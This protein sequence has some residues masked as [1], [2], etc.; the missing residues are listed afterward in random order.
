M[1]ANPQASRSMAFADYDAVV[2]GAGPAGSSAAASLAAHGRRVLLVERDRFP[3]HKVCGEFLSPEAQDTLNALDLTDAVAVQGPTSLTHVEV[4][5]RGGQHLR[6]PLPAA[7][8]GISR[9]AL[10]GA[11]AQAAA[12]R[13]VTLWTATT[14]VRTVYQGGRYWVTLRRGRQYIH[15]TARTVLLA[16]GRQVRAALCPQPPPRTTEEAQ[17]APLSRSVGLKRH[18]DGVAI[19]DQVEL[20]LFPGGY[21]GINPV[22][23]GRANLCLLVEEETFRAAGGQVESMIAAAGEANPALGERLAGARPVADTTCT[24]G[25]VNTQTPPRVWAG[26]PRLGDA[27][28]MLPPLCGDGMAMALRGAELCAAGAEAY[29][30]GE[31]TLAEW[32]ARYTEAWHT[33]FAERVRVAHALQRLL[34]MPHLAGGLLT[35]GSW[36]PWA[37]DYVVRATRGAVTHA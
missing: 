24:V 21:A 30:R 25:A 3:R 37:A 23:G 33:E 28:L 15:A 20:F 32:E 27:A 14:A 6:R 2:I 35:L 16:A 8:W 22:E 26:L 34:M 7:A 11:L 31:C 29:L 5:T 10:D 4:T 1:M 19:P 36:L 12:G 9:Y 13:G 17:S 18:L